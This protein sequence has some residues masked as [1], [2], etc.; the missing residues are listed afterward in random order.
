MHEAVWWFTKA[1]ERGHPQAQ[2]IVGTS[3]VAGVGVTRD[4]VTGYM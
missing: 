4:F 3:Y 2:Y 1:A